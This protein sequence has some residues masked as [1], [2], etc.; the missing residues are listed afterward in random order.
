MVK[1]DPTKCYTVSALHACVDPTAT[2][3]STLPG[4]CL[5]IDDAAKKVVDVVNE[6][7]MS[8]GSKRRVNVKSCY[9]GYTLLTQYGQLVMTITAHD[10]PW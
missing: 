9:N 4:I 6:T 7:L 10:R 1:T 3:F 8:E 2:E 5:T